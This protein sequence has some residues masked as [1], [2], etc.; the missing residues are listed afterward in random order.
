VSPFIGRLDDIS[1][2]GMDLVRDIIKIYRIYGFKTQVIAASIR[3]PVHVTEA[4]LAG[5]D[6]ATVPYDILKK[7]LKHNLTDEGIQKFLK[8]WESVKKK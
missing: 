3:H 7:M 8:D 5:A 2:T 4:A 6:V 1:H